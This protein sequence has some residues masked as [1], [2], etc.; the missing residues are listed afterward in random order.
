MCTPTK[1]YY[2]EIKKEILWY[3]NLQYLGES[4]IPWQKSTRRI[5]IFLLL[6]HRF[7]SD[8]T[9]DVFRT[10]RIKCWKHHVCVIFL[11]MLKSGLFFK[12]LKCAYNLNLVQF[13]LFFLFFSETGHWFSFLPIYQTSVSFSLQ[14]TLTFSV[15]HF[16]TRLIFSLLPT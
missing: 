5:L 3:L 16:N 1:D 12:Q 14:I 10:N 9:L 6:L 7:E 11:F 8:F 2:F 13:F 4:G 15:N